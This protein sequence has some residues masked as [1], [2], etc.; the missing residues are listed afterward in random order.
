MQGSR[1]LAQV[2]DDPGGMITTS[3]VALKLRIRGAKRICNVHA[4]SDAIVLLMMKQGKEW[5][6]S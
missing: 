4:T 2:R 5:G 1:D 3:K 6:G